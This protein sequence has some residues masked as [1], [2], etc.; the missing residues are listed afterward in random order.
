MTS[1]S[2]CSIAANTFRAGCAASN[3]SKMDSSAHLTISNIT[4]FAIMEGTEE[5]IPF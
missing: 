3:S 1:G 5:I 2:S 4:A